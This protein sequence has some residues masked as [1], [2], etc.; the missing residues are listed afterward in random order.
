[1]LYSNNF[2][3]KLKENN[4]RIPVLVSNNQS[5]FANEIYATAQQLALQLQTKGMTSSDRVVIAAE[6]GLDFLVIIYATM[7]LKVQ[8]AIIDPEMGRENYAAKL[9]QFNPTWAFVD[10]RLLLLQ[11][12]PILRFL[13]LKFSQNPVSFP[14]KKGLKIVSTGRW[15]PL[16]QRHLSLQKLVKKA[17]KNRLQSKGLSSELVV[18]FSYLVIYTSG[19]ITEPKGVLHSLNRLGNS[20]DLLAKLLQPTDSSMNNQQ[21]VATHLPHFM[22]IGVS[23]GIP[24]YLWDYKAKPADKIHFLEENQIT[25]LFG[26]PADYLELMTYCKEQNRQLPECLQHVILGSA[27]I[28][29]PFLERLVQFLPEHT[30]ITCLYGMTENLLVTSTDGRAKIAYTC[31]GDLL[32][33]PFDGVQLKIVE[34]GEILLSST[35]LFQRYWHL[36][37]RREWHATGDMGYIDDNGQLVLTSRKKQMIIRRNFNLYPALYEPTIK[38]I[39]GIIEAVLVGQYDEE[40]ADEKVILAVEKEN[41][42]TKKELFRQLK[43]GQFSIDNEAMPDEIVFMEIPRKGRQK[44]IDRKRILEQIQSS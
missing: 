2:L 31:K 29:V 12:H 25:T 4:S 36:E 15:L 30:R 24:I 14:W 44:K 5:V 6:P 28:H 13:Y 21:R 22:L 42:L 18:D 37:N 23:A 38:K 11:E 41:G 17:P 34:D 27:P 1:M 16:V 43:S 33:K 3:Q 20:I 19:T 8:V 40:K 7:F 26:P 10:I 9:K 32:G 39:Q 35:Q